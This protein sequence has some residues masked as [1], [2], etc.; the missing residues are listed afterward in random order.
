MQQEPNTNTYIIT[1]VLNLQSLG[2]MVA[3]CKLENMFGEGGGSKSIQTYSFL[4]F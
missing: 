2:A 4:N 1:I 3:N